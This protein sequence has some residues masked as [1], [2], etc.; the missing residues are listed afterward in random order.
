MLLSYD[1][2]WIV[3]CT[4]SHSSAPF[5]FSLNLKAPVLPVENLIL[6]GCGTSYFA[7]MCGKKYFKDLCKFNSI[8]VIDGAEFELNDI[9]KD[10]KTGLLLLSQSGETKD[11]Y[12][13]IVALFFAA[14]VYLL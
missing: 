4:F 12:C 11:L 7:G 2:A 3:C 10:G 14:R 8:Q 6:L 9:P 1:P 13:C 5:A